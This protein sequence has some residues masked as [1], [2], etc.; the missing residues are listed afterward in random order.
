VANNPFY[1]LMMSFHGLYD[2]RGCQVGV[3]FEVRI[4]VLS[5]GSF[6][7]SIIRKHAN[8]GVDSRIDKKFTLQHFLEYMTQYRE[9]FH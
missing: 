8:G 2:P 7:G 1:D 5:G 9:H 3:H 4:V 6:K